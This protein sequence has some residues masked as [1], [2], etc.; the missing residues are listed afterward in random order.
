LKVRF[1]GT[2]TVYSTTSS[3]KRFRGARKLG[4]QRL[5]FYASEKNVVLL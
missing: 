1:G 2:S 5:S 4:D 3:K